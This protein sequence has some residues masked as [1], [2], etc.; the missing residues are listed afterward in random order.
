[1]FLAVITSSEVR[2]GDL[3]GIGVEAEGHDPQHQSGNVFYPVGGR[4][5]PLLLAENALKIGS[6]GLVYTTPISNSQTK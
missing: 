3:G 1:M 5:R 2:K 4:I 6:R